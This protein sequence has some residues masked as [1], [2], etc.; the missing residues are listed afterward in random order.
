MR[1]LWTTRRSKQS[2]LK[3]VSPK[4][5]LEGLMLKLKLQ[6]FGHLMQRANLLEKT[7]MLGQIESKRRRHQRMRW[8]DSITNS[9]GM[10][11]SKLWEMVEDRGGCVLQCMGWQRV[12]HNLVT[13]QQQI[14]HS[15]DR[16]W[17]GNM[18]RSEYQVTGIVWSH[19][20]VCVRQI[21]DIARQKPCGP[22]SM[23]V[24]QSCLI[25]VTLWAVAHQAPLS[26]RFSRQ[27][28]WS[29]LPFPSSGDLPN[30]GIKPTSP[31][32]QEDSLPTE[33]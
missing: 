7:L 11:L 32:L 17:E 15:P 31:A 18:Q 1:V 19:L 6:Y 2:I 26:M 13:G 28:Y 4:C 5:S 20:G 16:M 27:E 29:G 3:E 22:C 21:L 12:R 23:L 14:G 10:S 25:L 24:T 8:S 9:V 30:P 33:L